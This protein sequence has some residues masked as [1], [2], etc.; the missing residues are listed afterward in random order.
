MRNNKFRKIVNF[1]M[2]NGE[3]VLFL[4]SNNKMAFLSIDAT[5]KY[6]Y[7]E[8]NKLFALVDIFAKSKNVLAIKRDDQKIKFFNFIPKVKYGT[9][10]LVISSALLSGCSLRND[11]VEFSFTSY[12]IPDSYEDN[13]YIVDEVVTK[14]NSVEEKYR[15]FLA[16]ADDEI[17]FRYKT[18]YEYY[19]LVKLIK[20]KDSRAY[21]EVFPFESVSLNDIEEVIEENAMIPEEFKHF[22]KEYARD[23]LSHYPSSDLRVFYHNLKTLKINVSSDQEISMATMAT[24]AV[25]CY[26][27]S[28]NAVYVR[29]NINL[30][31]D[32]T[33]YIIL[34][35]E[36]SHAL[37]G[38]IFKD[39]NDFEVNIGFYDYY[40]LGTYAEEAIITNLV[41]D[42]Q[43]L[44]KK[45]IY[46]SLQCSYFRIILDCIDYTGDDFTNHGIN[47]L[48]DKMDDFMGDEEYAYHII[49][50][51]E[52]EASLHYTS[53]A[54][55]DYH[56][57]SELYDYILRMY[58]KKHLKNDMSY[59]EAQE[60]F[61][62][63]I[64]EITHNFET[65]KNPY[66]ISEDTFIDE[67]EK[68][69]EE[70]GISK[71]YTK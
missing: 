54:S 52:A 10:L 12:N 33:D 4:D 62:T 43:G 1:Y 35:H 8:F 53:Y 22:V 60:L 39:K 70:I 30:S 55:V 50:L 23:W 34:C 5:G 25:A 18:D 42:L 59:E 28:E 20:I 47:Y 31:K 69:I 56:E 15:E 68:I 24:D 27:R 6:H 57:F 32:S 11:N 44:N 67:F 58:M 64:E 51:M 38:T 19:N 13:S 21:D 17:D 3:Y 9:I 63:F 45:S 65:M 46:Y 26:L 66:E 16:L 71:N 49:A 37:R 29:D 2:D 40:Q 48:F 41:Y 36:L 14:D 61:N 7:P